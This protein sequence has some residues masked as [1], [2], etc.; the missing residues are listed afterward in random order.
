MEI[1]FVEQFVG[2]HVQDP[3]GRVVGTL[4]SVYSNI[5]GEVEAVELALGENKFT[6]VPAERLG[7]K[8]GK[9]VIMPLWMS[10]ARSVY[11]KLDTAM[12]RLK[13]LETMSNNDDFN[14]DLV[15]EAKKKVEQQMSKLKERLADVK[16]MIRER[17]NELEDQMIQMEKALVNLQMSYIAG[18]I[19]ERRY[20]QAAATIRQ[21]KEIV[22]EE[23]RALKEWLEKLER[24]EREPAEVREQPKAVEPPQTSTTPI[25]IDLQD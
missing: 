7:K 12:R 13:A 25:M 9:L 21:Q 1:S 19:S 24:L 22:N 6:T 2:S 14:P 10:E 15:A 23:K 8:D 20:Q 11:R 18:E 16:R 5:D 3:F 4:V 17:I